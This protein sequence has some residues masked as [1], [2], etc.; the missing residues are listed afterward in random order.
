MSDP[1]VG[2]T[3]RNLLQHII[4]PKIVGATGGTYSVSTDIINVDNVF[5]TGMIRAGTS[6]A[7]DMQSSSAFTLYNP[8]NTSLVN[9]RLTSGSGNLYVQGNTSIQFGKIGT[10]VTNTQLTLGASGGNTDILNVGGTIQVTNSTY[11][12]KTITYSG[13]TDN[14]NGHTFSDIATQVGAGS[15]TFTFA[16]YNGASLVGGVSFQWVKSGNTTLPTPATLNATFSDWTT[17]GQFKVTPSQ[18]S[19]FFK[20]VLTITNIVGF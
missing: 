2:T 10:A 3:T 13:S 9:G 17:S 19:L 5:T 14:I 11:Q 18:G 16:Y 12:Q 15:G 7:G 8:L 1:Y 20:A 4:S 6:G